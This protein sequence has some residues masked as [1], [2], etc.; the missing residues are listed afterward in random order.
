MTK[1][2]VNLTTRTVNE[3]SKVSK[4]CSGTFLRMTIRV[5]SKANQQTK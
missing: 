4:V 1:Q 2:Q 5:F 3:I